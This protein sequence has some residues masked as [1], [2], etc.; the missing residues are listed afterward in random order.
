M[1]QGAGR[2]GQPNSGQPSIFGNTGPSFAPTRGSADSLIRRPCTPEC[3]RCLDKGVQVCRRTAV[4]QSAK[5]QEEE[6]GKLKW[7][8]CDL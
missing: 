1:V 7:E 2:P 3:Q 6:I 8:D 4:K 5:A